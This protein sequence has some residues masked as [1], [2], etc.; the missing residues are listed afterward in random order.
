[1]PYACAEEKLVL[2]GRY[3]WMGPSGKDTGPTLPY[4]KQ[5]WAAREAEKEGEGVTE[6]KAAE[7]RRTHMLS[8]LF[9]TGMYKHVDSKRDDLHACELGGELAKV[10]LLELKELQWKEAETYW[11]PQNNCLN[12]MPQSVEELGKDEGGSSASVRAK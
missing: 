10:M 7:V 9:L 6:E 2:V 5:G 12:Q 11:G 4:G 3:C 8:A 1:M